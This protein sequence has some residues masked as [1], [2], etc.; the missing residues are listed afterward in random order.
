MSFDQ[1]DV[2]LSIEKKPKTPKSNYAVIGLY[3]NDNR[4]C[5]FSRNLEP[6][7]R[8]E[9]EIADL[10]NWYLNDDTLHVRAMGSGHSWLDTE[11]HR[12]LLDAGDF[13]STIQNN[14]GL[15]IASREDIAFK[16]GWIDEDEVLALANQL[17]KSHYGLCLRN[18]LFERIS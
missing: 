10:N 13:V 15:L 3:F 14:Q 4:V 2:A 8:G 7:A 5:D 9:F 12:S 16:A 6:S 17:A 18:M 1:E 11:T